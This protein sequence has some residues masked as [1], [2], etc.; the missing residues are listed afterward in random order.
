MGTSF[1]PITAVHVANVFDHENNNRQQ[2][3]GPPTLDLDY[4]ERVQCQNS[5]EDWRK[6]CQMET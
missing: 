4:L 2:G 5:L 6:L 1:N 3:G